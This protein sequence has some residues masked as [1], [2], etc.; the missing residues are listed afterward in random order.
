MNLDIEF[1]NDKAISR[2]NLTTLTLQLLII[3]KIR[4]EIMTL[5]DF[6]GSLGEESNYVLPLSLICN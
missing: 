6:I 4:I 3:R 5:R 2:E 1:N